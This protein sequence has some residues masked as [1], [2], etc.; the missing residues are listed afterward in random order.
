MARVDL[1][2]DFRELLES[3]NSRG[4]RYLVLGGYAVNHYGYH[5]ATDDLDIWIAID[6]ENTER[7]SMA[8]QEFAGFPPS[9]VKPSM[10][11][12]RGKVFIFGREPARVDI[13]TEPSGVDFEACY[14][15]RKTVVWDGLKVPLISFEDLR[16][17]K[18]RSGRAKDLADLD[19][20]PTTPIRR[21]KGTKRSKRKKR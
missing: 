3:L 21:A 14:A 12:Q 16:T 19:N 8:L 15:R 13:L 7:V 2:P 20:L 10:F 5:R 17:N 18:R 1:F 9:K 4:V 11:R 6:P